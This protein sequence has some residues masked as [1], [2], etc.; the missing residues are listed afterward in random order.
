LR[1]RLREEAA[2]RQINLHLPAPRFCT[3]NAV[4]IAAA[5]YSVWQRSGFSLYPLE[6]DARSRVI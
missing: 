1:Q 5:A 4:M 2:Y 3:D 6:L